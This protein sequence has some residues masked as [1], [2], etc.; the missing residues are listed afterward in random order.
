M[1]R[2][3]PLRAGISNV[4]RYYDE[5]FTFEQGRLLL[6]GPNGS[7]KSKALEVLLPYLLDAS[8]QPSR[9]ST[10]G[11]TARTMHWNLMGEG[12]NGRTRVG[13][14]WLEFGDGVERVTIGAR[15]QASVSTTRVDPDYFITT[16]RVGDELRLT[17]DQGAPLTVAALK[18][19]LGDRGKVYPKPGEYR[20]AVREL[21]F[22]A[23]TA[24][25]YSTLVQALLQLRR[26]KL[27][28]HLDPEAVSGLLSSAL[29]PVDELQIA[30]LA[31]GF[32]RLDQQKAHLAQLERQEQ[33]ARELVASV[34]RYARS[35]IRRHATTLTQATSALDKASA[36]VRHGQEGLDRQRETAAEAHRLATESESR[37]E[38]LSGAKEALERSEAYAEGRNLEDL[39][40]RVAD[41][42]ATADR[43]AGDAGG[44]DA[45]A[46]ASREE[47]E[48]EH[49]IAQA[50]RD[51]LARQLTAVSEAAM[52]AALV[53]PGDL[54]LPAPPMLAPLP[55][56]LDSVWPT[57]LLARLDD[58]DA[59]D[60]SRRDQLDRLLGVLEQHDAAVAERTRREAAV[61][62]R[63]EQL[64]TAR[65]TLTTAVE[66]R[67]QALLDYDV[68][69][70]DWTDGTAVLALDQAEV[71]TALEAARGRAPRRP[72][73]PGSPS[74]S[75]PRLARWIGRPAYAAAS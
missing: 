47:A 31:E 17:D 69:V 66:D 44:A 11:T 70:L 57:H 40:Q 43:T 50:R 38:E 20:T 52:T 71:E 49:G 19:A 65:Q 73:P 26:P 14:V 18:E 25:R 42:R 29:P 6:R 30:E 32:E 13:F 10:F 62:G 45:K 1:T 59:R 58:L 35:E 3:R 12:A 4:W 9:L 5:V 55:E 56:A 64:T 15:L 34:R 60:R 7:G 67:E 75:R 68:A 33:A 2:W 72:S 54:K 46:A 74:W 27:S 37:R 41:A 24:D 16:A 61:D 63:S 23:M 48:H 8:T 36:D 53:V 21:L 28:E 51:E 22:P 39:R